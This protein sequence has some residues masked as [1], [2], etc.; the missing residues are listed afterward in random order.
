[1]SVLYRLL[2]LPLARKR[3][4]VY[5][6]VLYYINHLYGIFRKESRM[7]ASSLAFG[8]AKVERMIKQAAN[9]LTF[10]FVCLLARTLNVTSGTAAYVG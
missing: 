4:Y 10:F 1:M 5:P 7:D 3:G 9:Y 6:V 2:C 8:F